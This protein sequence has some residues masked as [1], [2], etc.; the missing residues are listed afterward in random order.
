[1]SKIAT[2][3]LSL[4]DSPL[5]KL[6]RFML[7]ARVGGRQADRMVDKF[8]GGRQAGRHAGSG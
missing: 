6:H 1:M 7:A 5:I 2:P 4:K 3:G 8:L